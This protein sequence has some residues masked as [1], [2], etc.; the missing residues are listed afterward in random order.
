MSSN[1]ELP[2]EENRARLLGRRV[3]SESMSRMDYPAVRSMITR[4]EADRD[5]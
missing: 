3:V 5:L 1:K 2:Q 4:P